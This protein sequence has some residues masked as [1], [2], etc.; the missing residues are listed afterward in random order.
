MKQNNLKKCPKCKR[1]HFTK[2]DSH[3]T[4]VCSWCKNGITLKRKDKK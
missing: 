1:Y 3:E 2:V 4:G